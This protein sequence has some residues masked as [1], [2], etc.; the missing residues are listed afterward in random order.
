MIEYSAFNKKVFSKVPSQASTI[1]DVGCG[2]GVLGKALREQK[3]DRLICGVTYSEEESHIA[4]NNLDEVWVLDINTETP[5]TNLKFDCIIFSHVLEHTFYPAKVLKMFEPFLNQ[6]GVIIIA[7][8]NIL[9]Y[10]QRTVFLKG[11]F[12][13]S[14]EGGLMDVTHFRFFDWKSA[15][16]LIAKAG[17]QMVSKEVEGHA[18]LPGFRKLFS[19]ISEKIDAFFVKKWPGLFGFQFVFV[20]KMP[21]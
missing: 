19:K 18:P 6:D 20:A 21:N 10:T 5:E 17:L 8:P 7:L 11:N 16:D 9:F 13:Y 14:E 4:K 1:L 12:Q 3:S 2:T 15:Q